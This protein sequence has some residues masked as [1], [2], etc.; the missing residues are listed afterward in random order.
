VSTD[1]HEGW[2][3]HGNRVLHEGVVR[4]EEQDVETPEGRRFAFPVVRSPGFAKVV[5]MMPNGD[6]VLVRQ[7]RHAIGTNT[8]EVPAGAID[9]GEAPS[10][11]ARRELQEEAL[12][13]CDPAAIESLGEFTTSPGRMDERGYLF[14][15]RDCTPAPDA[16]QHEPTEPVHLPLA[17]AIALIG[18]EVLAAS[19]SLALLLAERRL[20]E[21]DR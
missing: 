15:A 5:P 6:V 8:L 19:S 18:T 11:T 4:I 14:L 1:H 3:V 20:T 17:D 21:R 2:I 7:Y 13:T 9:A 16:Q 10:T 12:V